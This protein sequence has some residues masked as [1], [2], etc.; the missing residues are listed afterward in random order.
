MAKM[1]FST[2]KLQ[3]DKANSVVVITVAIAIFLT[4]F[5]L[6]A[7]K[8]LLGKRSYQARVVEGKEKAVKQL[9]ENLVA[10]RELV[11]AYKSF[12]ETPA[13]ILGGNPHGKG[14]K[15]GDNA[16]LILDALPS[17]YDYPALASSL[18]KILTDKSFILQSIEGT[19]DEIAQQQNPASPDPKVVEMP[20]EISVGST[21][22]SVPSLILL[23]ENSIRPFQIQ[24]LSISGTNANLDVTIK[25]KT[26]YLPEKNLSIRKEIVK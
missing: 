6:F 11:N 26:F 8:A 13:N 18:E 7:S 9:K 2:K 20:F 24:N 23:F 10:Q 25:A 17:K 16:R 14:E 3:I 19:D 22:D 1:S 12:V 15:D 21:Y 5:S 4:V